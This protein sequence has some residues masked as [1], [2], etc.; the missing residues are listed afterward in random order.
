MN[1]HRYA[2][3][4]HVHLDVF[5]RSALEVVVEHEINEF[6]DSDN[7]SIFQVWIVLPECDFLF[8]LHLRNTHSTALVDAH[9][10]HRT[11]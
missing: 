3:V 9:H 5:W 2:Q 8:D 10:M 4:E 11:M 1:T 7:A 6:I